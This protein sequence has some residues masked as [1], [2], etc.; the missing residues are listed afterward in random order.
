MIG[1]GTASICNVNHARW[2]Y[3]RMLSD[4]IERR[5][6]IGSAVSV[7]FPFRR[8]KRIVPVERF[9]FLNFAIALN[10]SQL[11]V[12][13]RVQQGIEFRKE[14]GQIACRTAA[15]IDCYNRVQTF[16]ARTLKEKTAS[17]VTATWRQPP[18]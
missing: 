11:V 7:C 9:D 1:H 2:F 14:L 16:L 5:A 4:V 15:R 17:H 8:M 6:E 13:K 18:P 10:D 3:F 12:A